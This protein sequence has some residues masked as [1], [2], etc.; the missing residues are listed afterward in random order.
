M[1]PFVFIGA[2]NLATS[3]ALAFF[4]TG[5]PI[6]QIY[7]RTENSARVLAQRVKAPWTDCIEQI[8]QGDYFYF[9]AL[10]D[11]VLEELVP[12]LVDGR[13]EGFFIHTAGSLP[14][15][16]WSQFSSSPS[17]Y[18]VFYP[19][20]TFSRQKPIPFEDIP[21]FIEASTPAAVEELMK[22]GRAISHHVTQTDSERRQKLHLAA[23]FA[24]NFSNHC[25]ALAEHLLEEAEIPFEVML[26]LIDETARKAHLLSPRQ[27][28]TGP[29]IRY[30]KSV[31]DRHLTVLASKPQLQEIYRLLSESIHKMALKP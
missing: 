14:M 11:S 22:L 6:A 21:I 23:V 10:K 27:G 2:G 28:Q 9:T 7:S 29:A 12:S 30:D 25:Y 13:E 8:L 16:L 5:F 31:I 19:M 18:G 1:A 3:L 15:S 17:R 20:Q 24:C 4:E 26:P